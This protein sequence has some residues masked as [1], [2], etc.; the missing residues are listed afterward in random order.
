[1]NLGLK[2]FQRRADKPD[3]G[4]GDERDAA[5]DAGAAAKEALAGK[6]TSGFDRRRAL[7]VV[8]VLGVA[9]SAGQVLQ[10]LKPSHAAVARVAQAE[11]TPG[12]AA[13]VPVAVETVSSPVAAPA[14]VVPR[15]GSLVLPELALA[16]VAP[17]GLASPA[18]PAPA[19]PAPV[20]LAAATPELPPA[21]AAPALALPEGPVALV[22]AC[23]VTLDLAALP[24]GLI[25]VT[26]DAPCLS[27]ARIVLAHQG[28]AVTGLTSATGR[29]FAT[30]PALVPEA[31]VEARLPGGVPAVASTIALPEVAAMRRFA[32]QWSGEDTFQLHAYLD[33][34]LFAT[35]GHI[36]AD[37]PGTPGG[38]EGYL[39][40]LGDPAA[41]LPLLAE[42]FT[43]PEGDSRPVDVV[44]ESEVTAL[45]CGRELLGETLASAGSAVTVTDLTLAMPGCDGLGDFLVLADLVPETLTLAAAATE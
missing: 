30:L 18:A 24:G 33:G 25:N 29:L 37:N 43:W 14:P 17:A 20:E 16:A 2:L 35:A 19:A 21:P 41:P 45:T 36:R 4:Q 9:F 1:M 7:R 8:A 11:S 42:V 27:D 34:A 12:A 32:V 3:T 15:P 5:Q 40:Q 10:T 23:P 6:G 44:V 31:R 22:E 38:E 13:Q 28:L 26:L 39:L